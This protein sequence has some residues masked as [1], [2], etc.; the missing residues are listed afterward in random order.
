MGGASP[1]S[2]SQRPSAPLRV[3]SAKDLRRW[4]SIS[5]TMSPMA[6]PGHVPAVYMLLDR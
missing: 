6:L 4:V 2:S 1:S 5:S 3:S